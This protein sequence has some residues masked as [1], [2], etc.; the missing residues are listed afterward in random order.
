VR[1]IDGAQNA[2]RLFER[3][4]RRFPGR[5]SVFPA[6]GRGLAAD[7]RRRAN[8]RWGDGSAWNED[9]SDEAAS[10]T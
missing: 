10:G 1:G 5:A 2:V 4:E 9:A 3:L 8:E 7:A 6:Y